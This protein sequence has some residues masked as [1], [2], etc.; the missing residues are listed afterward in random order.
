MKRRRAVSL[1]ET[2]VALFLLTGVVLVLVTL[3]HTLLRYGHRVEMQSLAALAAEKRIE[4]I[5]D[6]ARKKPGANYNFENL[7]SNYAGTV[8]SDPQFPGLQLT[9]QAGWQPLDLE[10][11]SF[12]Q[13]EVDK[14]RLNTSAALV[15][16][17][18]VW[19]AG[20]GGH[21]VVVT[22]LIAAPA[23]LPNSTLTITQVNG[24]SPITGLGT[25]VFRVSAKDSGNQPLP[26]LSYRW[27]ILPQT[28]NASVTLNRRDTT[29]AKVANQVRHADGTFGPT[30]GTCQL[31]ARATYRGQEL[32]GTFS[33][34]LAP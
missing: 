12:E 7:V 2:I 33:V 8:T 28:G 3:L 10:G 15:R 20:G 17:S 26:D 27:Y 18:A 6:W 16:V 11:S 22:S 5:R 1:A 14:K 29:E 13:P 9:T 30:S 23:R 24:G 31:E 19:I 25:G 21:S 4:Q 32:T 34:S